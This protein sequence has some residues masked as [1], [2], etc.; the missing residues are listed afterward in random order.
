MGDDIGDALGYSR[1]FIGTCRSNNR[2]ILVMFPHKTPT[3]VLIFG[4][5]VRELCILDELDNNE[6]VKTNIVFVKK[7]FRAQVIDFFWI[8]FQIYGK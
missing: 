7:I 4:L 8:F 6:Y 2:K 1:R 3:N 5:H